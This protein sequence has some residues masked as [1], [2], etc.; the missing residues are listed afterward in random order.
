MMTATVT[1]TVESQA[2][3]SPKATM[4]MTLPMEDRAMFTKLLPIRI[5]ES[6]SS[7]RSRLF[8]AR[9]ALRFP[10]SA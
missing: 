6:A 8:T 7:K 4:A 3:F 1:I 5:A 2:Y 9:A 10:S